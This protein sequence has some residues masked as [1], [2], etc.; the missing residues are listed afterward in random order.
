MNLDELFY[1]ASQWLK[2][3]KDDWTLEQGIFDFNNELLNNQL[4]VQFGI[5]LTNFQ[6]WLY[7]NSAPGIGL[8]AAI[9]ALPDTYA[10]FEKYRQTPQSV[11]PRDTISGV[12]NNPTYSEQQKSIILES[13]R[14]SLGLDEEAFNVLV[15][16]AMGEDIDDI[17][18]D[19]TAESTP[20]E[21]F[22]GLEEEQKIGRINDALENNPNATLAD[23]LD[24]L[25]SW[26]IPT[27]LFRKATG[28]T[29]EEYV[30]K[31]EEE[32]PG[33]EP[34][35]AGHVRD[36][37]PS[38]PTY[39][40]CVPIKTVDGDGDDDDDTNNGQQQCPI[41]QEYDETLQKCVPI[42][43]QD[44]GGDDGQGGNGK[45]C[46][47]GQVYDEAL[48]KCVPI[49]EEEEYVDPNAPKDRPL[50]PGLPQESTDTGVQ[51]MLGLAAAPSPTRTTESVL[52]MDLFKIKAGIPLVNLP[53]TTPSLP[54]YSN[55]LF[56][57][58]SSQRYKV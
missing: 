11:D 58:Y 44:T 47:I 35:Q 12:L 33:P 21:T 32:Q 45:S 55:P 46:P 49:K 3:V 20:Q 50:T 17:F 52:P 15:S 37:D 51:G 41:G 23:I 36:E 22:A 6:K 7:E 42:K 14:N 29:P 24:I 31:G 54:A 10:A 56:D 34:C 40:A 27:E 38:S 43:K 28:K 5:D 19:T 9:D 30:S 25:T 39:G 13:L 8:S 4:E 16:N 48:Q 2:G 53:V 18:T 1:N 26:N 57:I